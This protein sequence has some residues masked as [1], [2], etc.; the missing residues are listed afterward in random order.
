[1]NKLF[2]G[3]ISK[4]ELGYLVGLYY[5]DGY[6]NYN[7][8]DRH[9]RVEFYLNSRKDQD[10]KQLLK[11]IL[12]RIGLISHTLKDKRYNCERIR[13][14]NKELMLFLK[15]NIKGI[16]KDKESKIGFISG[17]IDSDGYINLKKSTISIMNTDLTLLKKVV[18]FLRSM[19]IPSK[20]SKRVFS[21]KDK[22]ISYRLNI[23]VRFKNL[24]HISKKAGRN[25]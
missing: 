23:S 22:K 6:S 10:I 3:N 15:Q 16:V 9:Y 19:N 8:K 20:L 21:R 11:D 2:L 1:M 18:K 4:K 25:L 12:T 5:G 24:K 7:T 13:I 17:L 14:S